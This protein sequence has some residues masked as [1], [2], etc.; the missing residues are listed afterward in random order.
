MIVSVRVGSHVV[1]L[2]LNSEVP[3]VMND[4]YPILASM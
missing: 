2:F 4:I 3:E 1:F